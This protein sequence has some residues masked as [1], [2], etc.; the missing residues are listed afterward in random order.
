MKKIVLSAL[1]LA[2]GATAS[3]H[4]HAAP[5][6][7]KIYACYY[8]NYS[9]AAQQTPAGLSWWEKRPGSGTEIIYTYE[10]F[11]TTSNTWDAYKATWAK[12]VDIGYGHT[13]WEFTFYGGPQCKRTVVTPGGYTISF[14]QCTDGH[15]RWCYTE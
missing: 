3:A 15:T 13:A 1:L 5:Q 8:T 11:K 6:T 10:H 12:P 4:A 7:G 14:E 2:L 9:G